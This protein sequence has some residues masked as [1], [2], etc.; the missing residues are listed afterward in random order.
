MFDS[1]F[2]ANFPNN[3]LYAHQ[4]RDAGYCEVVVGAH[5]L[6]R[7]HELHK[8]CRRH[9]DKNYTWCGHSFF[10]V[11]EKDAVFFALKWS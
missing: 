7:W 1:L 9:F 2:K 6:A 3:L 11:H 10:F 8:W 4:F 5:G